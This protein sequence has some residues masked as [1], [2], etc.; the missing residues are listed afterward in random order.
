MQSQ[1]S[2]LAYDDKVNIAIMEMAEL[3]TGLKFTQG[4]ES[5]FNDLKYRFPEMTQEEFSEIMKKGCLLEYGKIYRLT[6]STI[7][8]WANEYYIQKNGISIIQEPTKKLKFA[9]KR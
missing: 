8:E 4:K 9:I 1:E 3:R 6:V 5:I 7:C 2:I